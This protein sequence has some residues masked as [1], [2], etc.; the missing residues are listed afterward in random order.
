MGHLALLTTQNL[1]LGQV[2]L[3]TMAPMGGGEFKQG[4]ADSTIDGA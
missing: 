3:V 1:Y 2:E 4:H